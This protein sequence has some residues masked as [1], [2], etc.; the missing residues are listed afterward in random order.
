MR[1]HLWPKRY[2]IKVLGVAAQEHMDPSLSEQ[3]VQSHAPSVCRHGSIGQ[4]MSGT[5]ANQ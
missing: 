1:A 4:A 3:R 2:T 5:R